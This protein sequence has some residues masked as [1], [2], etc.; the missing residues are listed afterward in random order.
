MVSKFQ[1]VLKESEA[2]RS[3]FL[4]ARMGDISIFK[5][6]KKNPERLG[7]IFHVARTVTSQFR[8]AFKESAVKRQ[9]LKELRTGDISISKCFERIG[10]DSVN[11]INFHTRF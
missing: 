11:K 1:N 4:R 5:M 2:T 6:F 8:N 9:N 10:G 3:N 7:Q